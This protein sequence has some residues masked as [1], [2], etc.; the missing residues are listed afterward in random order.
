M[1]ATSGQYGSWLMSA[2]DRPAIHFHYAA[3][4]VHTP[5]LLPTLCS[6]YFDALD[7]LPEDR[8]LQ[9]RIDAWVQMHGSSSKHGANPRPV[10]SLTTQKTVVAFVQRGTINFGSN[11]VRLVSRDRG[12]RDAGQLGKAALDVMLGQGGS[13][14]GSVGPIARRR[15]TS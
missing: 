4:A 15:R 2:S 10:L 1:A 9:A 11:A 12:Y 8:G 7:Q 6:Y 14:G 3:A 5:A 13:S